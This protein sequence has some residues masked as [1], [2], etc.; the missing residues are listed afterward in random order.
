[1]AAFEFAAAADHMTFAIVVQ[2]FHFCQ[3]IEI[4]PFGEAGGHLTRSAV[5]R[6]LPAEDQ[7][8]AAHLADALGK[9]VGGGQRVGAAECAVAQQVDMLG[10]HRQSPT[11]R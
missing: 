9:G 4:Q 8:C 11:R 7:V 3:L 6:L 10:A 2:T 1:M 5:R